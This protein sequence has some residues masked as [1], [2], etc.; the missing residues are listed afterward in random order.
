MTAPHSQ[1]NWAGDVWL[2]L[3]AAPPAMETFLE[4]K[5]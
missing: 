3:A 2:W 5:G 4:P 1:M